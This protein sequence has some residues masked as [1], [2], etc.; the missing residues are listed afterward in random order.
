[1][2]LPTIRA[3]SMRSRHPLP[4][5]GGY[6]ELSGALGLSGASDEVGDL[7]YFRCMPREGPSCLSCWLLVSLCSCLHFYVSAPRRR[8]RKY[9]ER[10][11]ERQRAEKYGEKNLRARAL[12]VEETSVVTIGARRERFHSVP[13]TKS[14]WREPMQFALRMF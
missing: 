12:E 11:N 5:K 3:S 1:M 7:T 14:R 13:P 4:G 8:P 2:V 6:R 9:S 10:W